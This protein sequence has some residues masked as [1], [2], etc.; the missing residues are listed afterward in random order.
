MSPTLH[1][2][3]LGTLEICIDGKNAEG[4][5]SLKAQ[6][7]LAYLA[8][9]GR[10]QSRSTLSGLLWGESAEEQARASLR[11]AISNINELCEGAL[12][13]TRQS[14]AFNRH[15]PYTLDSE[16]FEAAATRLIAQPSL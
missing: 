3:F 14:V 12:I 16:D 5:R 15:Q 4:F 6:A 11:Q 9:S 13:A 1:L 2:T 10:A 8:S 7:L